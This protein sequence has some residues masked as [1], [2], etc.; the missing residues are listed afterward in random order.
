MTRLLLVR[1]GETEWNSDAVYRGRADV[2]LSE[3]GVEQ[4]A[5]LGARLAREGVSRVLSSPLDRAFQTARAIGQA[6]GL[7]VELCDD[8]TDIDCGEWQ[9]LNDAMVRERYP[10]L[11]RM[12]LRAP[13]LVTLPGGESL[14]DVRGRASR[15]LDAVEQAGGTIALVSHR[16]V[17]KVHICLLLG[18]DPSRFWE[19]RVDLAAVT[20]FDCEKGRRILVAH[21]DTCHLTREQHPDRGDF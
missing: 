9:G 21:N 6:C 20:V 12:W 13:H 4:A 16:V 1:H 14:D 5:A 3:R 2:P 10:D 7:Q 11:R 8:L 19:I 17:N 18:L 15:V